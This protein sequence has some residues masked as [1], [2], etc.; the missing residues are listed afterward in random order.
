MFLTGKKDYPVRK[1][2][3]VCIEIVAGGDKP[4]D[5][6]DE[7]NDDYPYPVF[8]NAETNEGLL[9]YSR[10]YRM[11]NAGVTVAARGCTVGF[12]AVREGRYTPVVRLIALTP[13]E[14][15]DPVF[16]KHYLDST[17]LLRSTGSA[18][19]QITIPSIKN[20]EIVVP[21]VQR[22]KEYAVLVEQS[23]K[24]KYIVQTI[25]TFTMYN[26]NYICFHC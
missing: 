7:K 4:K 19:P 11:E 13:G 18:Q 23:D 26:T 15:I 5:I 8:A 12:T 22:Q 6:S 16:L 17:D 3:E 14:E 21:P 1:L 9:C 25:L 24:S 10:T 2:N 20:I